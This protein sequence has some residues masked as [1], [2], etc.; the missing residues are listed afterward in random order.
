[1]KKLLLVI[2][3]AV[4]LSAGVSVVIIHQA[5]P[6]TAELDAEI[7]ATKTE[8]AGAEMEAA[9]YSGGIILLQTQLRVVTLKNTLAMLEQKCASFLRGITLVYRDPTPRI[10]SPADDATVSSEL[11]RARANA[12]A[13]REEAEM[14]SGGLFKTMALMREATAKVTEAAIEQRVAFIKLGLPLA[15]TS[16]NPPSS[17]SSPGKA[18]SDKD[19]LQ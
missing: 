12:E 13:A 8:I 2:V 15:A 5:G 19:A 10:A 3:A 1:M 4:A 16:D 18:T 6:S 7:S 17:V 9:Q 11:E 14:Y